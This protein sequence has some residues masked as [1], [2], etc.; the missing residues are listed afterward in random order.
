MEQPATAPA[1]P[2]PRRPARTR[3]APAHVVEAGPNGSRTP[4]P[5]VLPAPLSTDPA[6]PADPAADRGQRYARERALNAAFRASLAAPRSRSSRPIASSTSAVAGCPTR[7]AAS[8]KP[9]C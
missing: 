6:D 8:K 1:A 2:S 4:V 7:H 3:L 5:P 9:P